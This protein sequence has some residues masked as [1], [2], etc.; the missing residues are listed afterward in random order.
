MRCGVAWWC[1]A[2]MRVSR[3]ARAGIGMPAVTGSELSSGFHKRSLAVVAGL[4]LRCRVG[5]PD[6]VTALRC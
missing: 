2:S 4:Q 5:I 6:R 1:Q 3:S